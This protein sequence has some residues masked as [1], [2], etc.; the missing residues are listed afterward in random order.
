MADL[1]TKSCFCCDAPQIEARLQVISGTAICCGQPAPI[2]GYGDTQYSAFAYDTAYTV[3]T[4]STTTFPDYTESICTR[5]RSRSGSDY[6]AIGGDS[7]APS[8]PASTFTDSG[9]ES[10]YGSLL[11][12]GAVSPSP[13]SECIANITDTETSSTEVDCSD[14]AVSAEAEEAAAIALPFD[15]WGDVADIMDGEFSDYGGG[16]Y[17]KSSF[18]IRKVGY[19]VPVWIVLTIEEDDGI[20]APSYVE[21]TILLPWGETFATYELMP[22]YGFARTI[23]DVKVFIAPQ[24]PPP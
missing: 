16:S 23:I 4:Y 12:C 18:E 1:D 3:R 24:S 8:C 22:A 17:L 14:E 20:G 19:P 21:E 13:G 11:P 5:S 10:I 2:S 6:A 7:G 15:A 9:C